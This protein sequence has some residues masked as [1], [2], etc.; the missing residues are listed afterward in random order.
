LFQPHFAW[1]QFILKL[2]CEKVAFLEVL[3]LIGESPAIPVDGSRSEDKAQASLTAI[4]LEI[5]RN[6]YFVDAFRKTRTV[7]SGLT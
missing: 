7:A 6:D 3:K 2:V 5:T 1:N 4:V